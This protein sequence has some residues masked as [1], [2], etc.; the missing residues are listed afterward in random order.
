MAEA[1]I[2][3]GKSIAYGLRERVAAAAT[4][5][6]E[7]HG[8]TAGLAAVLVGDDPASQIYVRSKAR[9]CAAVGLASL[10]FRLPADA[11]FAAILDVVAKLNIDQRVDGILVQ[12][13]LPSGID[14]R[15]GVGA[16]DSAQ[17]VDGVHSGT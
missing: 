6:R 13:P 5:L 1:S 14:R 10:E 2:I 7:E 3:D 11:G 17:E 12:L 16:V 15:A 9:A 8:I 4:T